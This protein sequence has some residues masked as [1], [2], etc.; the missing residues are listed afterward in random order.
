MDGRSIFAGA[1]LAAGLASA[2]AASQPPPPLTPEGWG[3]VRI[4]MPEAE[5]TRR[6]GMVSTYVDGDCHQ[7]EFRGRIDLTGIA[8][9]GRIASL[10]VGGASRLRT[11]RGIRIGSTERDVRRAYGPGLKIEPNHYRDPPAHYLT[12]WVRPNDRGV[13]FETDPKG[14]VVGIHVGDETIGW[15]DGCG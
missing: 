4:G 10:M 9:K 11:D 1:L 12:F 15:T 8:Q 5:A 14:A 7:L 3:A 13:M 6:F 2:G